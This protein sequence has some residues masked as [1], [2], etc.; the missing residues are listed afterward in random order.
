MYGSGGYLL[1][2]VDENRPLHALSGK[3]DFER[4]RDVSTVHP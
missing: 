1:G 2:M 3:V 4:Y